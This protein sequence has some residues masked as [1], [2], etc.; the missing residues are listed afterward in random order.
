MNNIVKNIEYLKTSINNSVIDY[1]DT[2]DIKDFL[3]LK[4][5]I[6]YILDTQ[7][8][9]NDLSSIENKRFYKFINILQMLFNK[10][11]ID[12]FDYYK[13]II[14]I[15]YESDVKSKKVKEIREKNKRK[16]QIIN[17]KFC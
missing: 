1:K 17:G 15:Q 9:Y 2:C 13:D 6:N 12:A 14:R 16:K 10:Y 5:E 4:S 7:I 11:L 8:K 3:Y